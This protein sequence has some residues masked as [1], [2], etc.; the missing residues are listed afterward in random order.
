[1]AP[2]AAIQRRDREMLRTMLVMTLILVCAAPTLAPAG[3]HTGTL[4]KIKDSKT[5]VLGYRDSSWPFSYVGD[6]G[7]P[8]GY[9]VDL[10]LRIAEAVQ[11]DLALGELR[12]QWTKVTPDDRIKAVVDGRIDLECGSTTAS[13]SRQ[14]QVDFTITTFVDGGSLLA[15]DASGIE[16]VKDLAGKKLAIVR[17]TT[18]ETALGKA[19]H[20]YMVTPQIVA[21]KD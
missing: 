7:K 20:K 13:L 3:Q 9:S 1:M 4:K 18:T 14:T 12:V 6:D 8:A 2:E 15:T 17:G 16:S 11:R 5:I 10:C 21:V 19:L